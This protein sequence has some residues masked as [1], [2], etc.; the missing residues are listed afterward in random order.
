[1]TGGRRRRSMRRR[2]TPARPTP[3]RSTRHPLDG[4]ETDAVELD[5]VP[6]DGAE[7]D[8]VP[9][10]GAELDAGALDGGG[11]GLP[12]SCGRA[13]D[14][15]PPHTRLSIFPMPAIDF[16]S[17]I[18]TDRTFYVINDAVGSLGP[19]FIDVVGTNFSVGGFAQGSTLAPNASLMVVVHAG[20]SRA[21]SRHGAHRVTGPVPRRD[22]GAGCSA[23]GGAADARAGAECR[24]AGGQRG[25]VRP[26][27]D[28]TTLTV[29]GSGQV[30]VTANRSIAVFNP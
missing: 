28:P 18:N 14:T 23:A 27:G 7:L 8:A 15:S 9:V 26:G 19:I 20:D 29:G 30:L 22:L 4:P 6:V 13:P 17:S 21:A 3:R 25:D 24:G 5:A 12:T 11:G 2:S 1:M 16:G 10:D